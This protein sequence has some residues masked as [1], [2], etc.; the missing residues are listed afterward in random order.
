MKKVV[1]LLIFMIFVVC[2]VSAFA[3][4][5]VR[6][7]AS[8]NGTVLDTRTKLMW[9]AKD[10]GSDIN[11]ASAVS[12]C[13]EYR[14]GDFTNWRLPTISELEG[15]YD[16]DV[17]QEKG[18]IPFHLTDLITLSACCPWTS[19]T[20]EKGIQAA[21]LDFSDGY[22]MWQYWTYGKT[23]PGRALPVRSTR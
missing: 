4:E 1:S 19:E 8:D 2:S 15:L 6:F 3:A 7:V 23:Y 9:A 22:V 21:L 12:Y 20:R 13:E 5:K 14:G 18:L 11:W 16:D 17:T 10:N